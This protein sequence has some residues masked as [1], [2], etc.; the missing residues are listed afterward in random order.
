MRE[1]AGMLRSN[2][3][4]GSAGGRREGGGGREAGWADHKGN[5]IACLRKHRVEC[6]PIGL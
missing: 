3:G 1:G 2:E 6:C 4:E 5:K